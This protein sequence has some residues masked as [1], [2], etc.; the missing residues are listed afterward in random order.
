VT[1]PR[2][3]QSQIWMPVEYP[4]ISIRL[5]PLRMIVTKKGSIRYT[6]IRSSIPTSP[7][8]CINVRQLP[9]RVRGDSRRD[10]GSSGFLWERILSSSAIIVV[11]RH[12]LGARR[13]R[14]VGTLVDGERSITQGSRNHGWRRS[15]GGNR[16]IVNGGG[17]IGPY[18]ILDY[19]SGLG[20]VAL[21]R[22]GN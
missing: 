14:G 16:N 12:V 11:K 8:Y 10:S 9:C 4:R 17:D 15:S 19:R 18:R 2:S 13:A 5:L 20:S 22:P 1:E 6:P 7:S 21:Y 3:E